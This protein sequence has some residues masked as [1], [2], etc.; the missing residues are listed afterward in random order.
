MQIFELKCK[1]YI[2][3]D[4]SFF[5]S[6]WIV[7]KFISFSLAKETQFLQEHNKNRFKTYSFSSF[8]ECE[9]NK[10]PKEIKE[11]TLLCFK[12]RTIDKKLAFLLPK[13]LEQNTNN[14]FFSVVTTSL[15]TIKPFYITE[16]YTL[17]PTVISIENEGFW[18]LKNGDIIFLQKRL[19]E[20][21]VKKYE[22]FYSDI[23]PT[24]NFIQLLELKNKTPQFLSIKK[25][26]QTI[27]LL[28]NK[29]RIVPHE[30][31][32]SQKLAF[33]ALGVGLGEKNTLGG[34]FVV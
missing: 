4:F 17:T 21:L 9:K 13:L 2:K 25:Q 14:Q 1:A 34:G 27:K 15:K 5:E 23:T 32:I 20:N 22:Q 3:K 19:H 31:E 26:N 8:V 29:F 6:F 30:D 24:Q 18:S 11:G 16:L 12:I 28:G 33:L 10:P 7:S